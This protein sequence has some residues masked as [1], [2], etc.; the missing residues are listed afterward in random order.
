[1]EKSQ[2]R[3]EV[4]LGEPDPEHVS[5]SFVESQNLSVRWTAVDSLA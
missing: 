3:E 5:T 2:K 1:M 4:L